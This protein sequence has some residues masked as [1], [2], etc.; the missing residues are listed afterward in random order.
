MNSTSA[1]QLESDRFDLEKKELGTA[2]ISSL[3][4]D[5]LREI[6]KH[7]CSTPAILVCDEPVVPALVYSQVCKYWRSMVLSQSTLWSSISWGKKLTSGLNERD[8]MFR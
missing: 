2:S 3:N 8:A 1:L 7:G 4:Q 6:F 5:V